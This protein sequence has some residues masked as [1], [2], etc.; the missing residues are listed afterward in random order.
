MLH[1]ER[2]MAQSEKTELLHDAD[3]FRNLGHGT[4]LEILENLLEGEKNVTELLKLTGGMQQG[5]L[6]SHLG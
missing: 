6:S 3:L 5:R 2:D 1:K 4:R